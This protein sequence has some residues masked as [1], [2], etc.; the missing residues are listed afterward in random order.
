MDNKPIFVY[1]PDLLQYKFTDGHPFTQK[2]LQLTLSLMEALAIVEPNQIVAPRMAT[3]EEIALVH[4]PKFI[5]AVRKAGNVEQG[6]YDLKYGLG[7]EDVPVFA[8]MHE[9]TAYVVGG[10]LDVAD[11]VMS[12]RGAHGVNLSGGLHHAFRAKASG[13]CVYNDCSIV[14]AYLKQKYHAR[15]LYVDTDAHH[16][17]G[18][19]WAFYNDPDVMTLSIHETGK[20]LFL[21]PAM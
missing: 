12:N 6:Y 9:A 20:Y 2:R 4:D 21:E 7:T 15:V 8:N 18:V 13:F 17:D 19:Q 11:Y 10:S 16:G 1:S 14:I 3:D 5:D